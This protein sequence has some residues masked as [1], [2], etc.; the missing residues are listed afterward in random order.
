[1][2]NIFKK[3]GVGFYLTLGACVFALIGVVVFLMTNSTSGYAITNGSMGIIMGV[4]AIVALVL[5]LFTALKFG[6]QSVPTVVLKLLALALVMAALGVLIADRAG[7]ASSLFT[8]D[9][10]NEV[11]WS[12]FYTSVVSMVFLLLS[13]LVLIVTGFMGDKKQA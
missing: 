2:A 9:S 7:L 3:A 12:V 11:G 10:H 5:S 1:M 8:Y 6:S 4:A 13:V